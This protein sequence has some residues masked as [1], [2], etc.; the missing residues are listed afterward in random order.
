[1][2]IFDLSVPL[3]SPRA[4]KQGI[5]KDAQVV[6]KTMQ[7]PLQFLERCLTSAIKLNIFLCSPKVVFTCVLKNEKS[8]LITRGQAVPKNGGRTGRFSDMR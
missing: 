5:Y 7:S 1:M 4:F 2:A 3:L 6:E 8:Y